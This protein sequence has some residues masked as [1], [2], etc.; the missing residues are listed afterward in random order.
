MNTVENEVL[1]SALRAIASA[2]ALYREGQV[3]ESHE[4]LSKALQL[5]VR[6]WLPASESDSDPTSASEAALQELQKAGYRR[7]ERL[8]AA[9]AA[10]RAPAAGSASGAEDFPRDTE[11]LWAEVERVH[12]FSVRHFRPVAERKRRRLKLGIALGLGLVVALV[13]V[14]RLWGRPYAHAS[15]SFSNAYRPAHALDGLEATEWLLPETSRGWID[16]FP[17]KPRTLHGVRLLNAHNA[18]NLD[19]ATRKVRVTAYSETGPVGSVEGEYEKLTQ[20][21]SILDLRLEAEHVVRVR[22]EVLG[23]FARGGGF[24]EIEL[25]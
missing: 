25:H 13:F 18:Y 7:P 11:W 5:L 20:D 12:R 15:A 24:A 23:F 9:L 19:R 10:T 17:P 1:A 4:Y 6:A 16:I 22:I 8:R 21:T 14:L 2:R 3:P